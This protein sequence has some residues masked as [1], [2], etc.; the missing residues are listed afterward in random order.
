M[1][2]IGVLIGAALGTYTAYDI[3]ISKELRK[4]NDL[5]ELEL[6]QQAQQKKREE[7]LNN[8]KRMNDYSLIELLNT[9]PE[10][11]THS[12]TLRGGIGD[13][14]LF[15]FEEEPEPNEKYIDIKNECLIRNLIRL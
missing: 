10:T 15:E 11:I 8:L 9:T 7:W 2:G 3:G 4:Q 14:I 12:P 5:K 6:H 1:F 13:K